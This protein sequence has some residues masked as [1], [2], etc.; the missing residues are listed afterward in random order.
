MSLVA[1]S[2]LEPVAV[3]SPQV[4]FEK[5]TE[6][7]KYCVFKGPTMI[8]QTTATPTGSKDSKSGEVIFDLNISDKRS[9]CLD[10]CMYI[11]T[12]ATIELTRSITSG[13][14]L[15]N[16]GYVLNETN[17]KNRFG[18]RSLMFGVESI[19]YELD[20][21]G[22]PL[23]I[24]DFYPYLQYFNFSDE[25]L[26]TYETLFPCMLDN[27]AVFNTADKNNV[28]AFANEKNYYGSAPRG[29]FSIQS[30]DNPF[31][32]PALNTTVTGTATIKI[33]MTCPVNLSPFLS[34][35]D[36]KAQDLGFINISKFKLKLTFL[37]GDSLK[38]RVVSYNSLVDNSGYIKVGTVTPFIEIPAATTAS[39]VT[40]ALTV[41]TL[42][43]DKL[44]LLANVYSMPNLVV[45]DPVINY[46]W[47]DIGYYSSTFPLK[48]AQ[49]AKDALTIVPSDEELNFNNIQLSSCPNKAF[50]FVVPDGNQLGNIPIQSQGLFMLPI[51]KISMTFGNSPSLL[52][53]VEK[54]YLYQYSLQN[55]MKYINYSDTGL[56]GPQLVNITSVD[57]PTTPARTDL[58]Y[59]IP[60]GYP[61]CL[62]FCS[63]Q[64]PSSAYEIQ[65]PGLAMSSNFSFKI[66]VR[67]YIPRALSV[68][69]IVVLVNEGILSLSDNDTHRQT[70]NVLSHQDILVSD[71]NGIYT[72]NEI[73]DVYNYSGGNPFS[74]LKKFARKGLKV[75]K[76]KQLRDIVKE[77]L[78]FADAVGVPGVDQIKKVVDIADQYV[79][80]TGAGA[81]VAGRRMKQGMQGNA[82]V[83]GRMI[84]PGDLKDMQGSQGS[85]RRFKY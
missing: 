56:S 27:A 46:S 10:K 76:S 68:K 1:E 3:Y 39:L 32:T 24:S 28:L 50:I 47:N 78:K 49:I 81:Y 82:M 2:P 9:N 60:L 37:A 57:P 53:N 17:F 54:E 63:N 31:I 30:I 23:R 6:K 4:A 13:G 43:F 70:I 55:G 41:S 85:G 75:L 79:P 16:G 38:N 33:E 14:T 34:T 45:P 58:L 61:L 18:L 20:N 72:D 67:N 26:E 29:S 80:A 48:A 51:S 19:S 8:N 22:K 25:Q 5:Q 74:K 15:A 11:R 84:T 7:D 83:A 69:V 40:G 12:V 52:N 64:I 44:E 66:T 42:V 77:G 36:P 62:S 71:D 65:A 73:P 21:V 35:S 59:K